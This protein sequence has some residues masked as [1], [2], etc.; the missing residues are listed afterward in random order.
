M[1]L[2]I[3][4]RG[5]RLLAI[6]A[7]ALVFWTGQNILRGLWEPDEARYAYVATEMHRDDRWLVPHVHGELYPDKPPLLFWLI[8]AA[9]LVTGGE[10]TS[11]SA[12]LPSLFGAILALWMT[13]RLLERWRDGTTAWRGVAVLATSYLFWQE[14]GWGRIDALLLGLEMGAVYSFFRYN[15]TRQPW[16]LLVAWALIGFAMLAKGP[17][18]LAVPVLVYVAGSWAAGGQRA[19]R[20]WHWAWGIPLACAIP[21]VWLLAAW[22]IGGAPAEYFEA[23]FTTK[24]FTRVVRDHH[25][26][27]FYYYLAHF[28]VEFLTWMIFLPAAIKGLEAGALRRRLLAWLIAMVV[29]FS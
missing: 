12:R 11:L 1:T 7:L 10:I 14:A 20:A 18:A 19:L 25:A 2:P 26:K 8:N 22:K 28:P 27:P 24:S 6:I 13:A 4:G 5:P 3:C 16:R 15:D 9:S 21:G 29:L 23:M 17:V